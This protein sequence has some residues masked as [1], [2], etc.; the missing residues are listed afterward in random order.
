MGGFFDR[1]GGFFDGVG[2]RIEAGVGGFF[3]VAEEIQDFGAGLGQR[4]VD[5]LQGVSGSFD[6]AQREAERRARRNAG[7]TFGTGAGR[8]LGEI[9]GV[10]NPVW[11]LAG[12]IVL[13]L[14]L[15]NR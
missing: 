1:V 9:S 12:I 5:L 6:N 10:I 4:G 13:F 8:A 14:L 15:Q 7:G 2:S 3:D 11:I